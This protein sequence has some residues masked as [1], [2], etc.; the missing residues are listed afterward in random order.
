MV[1]KV[2]SSSEWPRTRGKRR[3]P[4]GVNGLQSWRSPRCGQPHPPSQS[5][6]G[7]GGL[8][9]CCEGD[10]EETR[11]QQ[12]RLVHDGSLLYEI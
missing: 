8:R 9:C 5:E 1:M 11:I 2:V 6:T 3:G 4:G 10:E 12:E 7:L